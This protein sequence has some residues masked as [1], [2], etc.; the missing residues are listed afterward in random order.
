MA[1]CVN[2]VSQKWGH[3]NGV[4][5]KNAQKWGQQK[6][7]QKWG[8]DPLIISRT[9]NKKLLTPFPPSVWQNA[10][11]VVFAERGTCSS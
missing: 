3:K 10:R 8:Q 4:S 7:V 6:C 9:K 1:L 11:Q 5:H 2:G